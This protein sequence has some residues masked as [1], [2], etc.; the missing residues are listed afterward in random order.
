MELYLI[1]HGES[2]WNKS[3]RIQGQRNP[4]LTNKGEKQAKLLRNRLLKIPFDFVYSSPLRRAYNTAEIVMDGRYEIQKDKRIAEINLGDWE[5][6]SAKKLFKEDSTFRDWFE[7]TN[8]ITPK[9]GESLLEFKDRVVSFFDEIIGL[10][11]EKHRGIVFTHSGVI[12]IFLVHLLKMD[13]NKVWSIPTSHCSI[14]II[15]TNPIFILTSF[16]DTC[17]LSSP[18]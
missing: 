8:E 12:S 13:L 4:Y 5:G 6:I 15:T 18:H 16:N 2:T 9:N 14:T 7:R 1:R 10:Q 17:H 11:K 3:D